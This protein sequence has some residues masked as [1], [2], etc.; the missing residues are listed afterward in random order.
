MNLIIS[1][2][3][4]AGV[5]ALENKFYLFIQ[6]IAKSKRLP[7]DVRRKK[8]FHTS[9]GV[10]FFVLHDFFMYFHGNAVVY[11]PV[12]FTCKSALHLFHHVS[13]I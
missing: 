5:R 11:I 2:P 9:F 10:F 12:N 1:I 6:I 3:F 4:W 7:N 8:Y 13:S